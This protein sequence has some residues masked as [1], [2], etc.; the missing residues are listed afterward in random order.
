MVGN[1]NQFGKQLDILWLRYLLLCFL[2]SEMEYTVIER[3]ARGLKLNQES[4]F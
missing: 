4:I 3:R 1:W 2:L